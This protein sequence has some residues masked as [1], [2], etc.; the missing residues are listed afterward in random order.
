MTGHLSRS[1]LVG[2]LIRFQ[3]DDFL[4]LKADM[5]AR[6]LDDDCNEKVDQRKRRNR[7]EYV[8]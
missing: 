2:I 3:S 4:R 5:L 1:E 6:L 8:L 7:I